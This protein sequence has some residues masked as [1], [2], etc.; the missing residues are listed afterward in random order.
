[1]ARGDGA[2]A[3]AGWYVFADYCTGEVF[4]LLPSDDVTS[5]E[6]VTL[7]SAGGSVTAVTSGP[8]G[9]VYVL[10]SSGVSRLVA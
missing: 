9:T 10:D 8:D 3:L 1:M 4:G 7:A 2:G 6:V 5:A